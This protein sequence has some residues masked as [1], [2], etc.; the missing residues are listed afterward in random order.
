MTTK[1]A[2]ARRTHV[3]VGGGTAGLVLVH[4][5]LNGGDDVLLVE[6]GSAQADAIPDTKEAI[7][8][9]DAAVRHK[10]LQLGTGMSMRDAPSRGG[11]LRQAR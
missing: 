6:Q 9:S 10:T 4:L 11:R 3:V 7:T 2:A 8:W 5:L 1:D